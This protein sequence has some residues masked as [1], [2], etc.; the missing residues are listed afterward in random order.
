MQFQGEFAGLYFTP[1]CLTS[2]TYDQRPGGRESNMLT[3]KQVTPTQGRPP[4]ATLL[5]AAPLP[6][7]PYPLPPTPTLWPNWVQRDAKLTEN[8]SIT[9][10]VC[11][12]LVPGEIPPRCAGKKRHASRRCREISD[13][14]NRLRCSTPLHTINRDLFNHTWGIQTKRH[15]KSKNSLL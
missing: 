5:G 14:T 13:W 1:A 2:G 15:N 11:M 10:S 8:E 6:P 12:V 7:P 9:L 4:Y 3:T